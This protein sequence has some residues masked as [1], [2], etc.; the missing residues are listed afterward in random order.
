M[1]AKY[2]GL[3]L[4]G[5]NIKIAVIENVDGNWNIIHKDQVATEAISGPE[6]VTN[7][8]ANLAAKYRNEFQISGVGLAVPGIFDSKAGT[9]SL[10]PNLP[11]QWRGFQILK[12]ITEAAKVPVSL[13]NDARAFSLAESVLGAARGY[14]TVA[15]IVMGTGVGGGIVINGKVHL[16]ATDG[17]GEIAHQIVNPDGPICGCGSQGC[18][19]AMTSSHA[20]AT[21]AGVATP[22]EAFERA[23]AG[24]AQAIKAFEEAGKWIGIAMANV[25]AILSPDVYVLGGGVSQSGG[26]ITK[27]ALAEAH[28][29]S[30]LFDGE[31]FHVLPAQLD[32]FAGAIGAA[33]NGSAVVDNNPSRISTT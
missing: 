9:I 27:Y 10:F 28:R 11:G 31:V 2:L 5:T 17:A 1:N 14:Q 29:R 18:V 30:H 32:V 4:G 21:Y 22:E 15:C 12:P 3:D 19:E 16:G 23:I 24:D 13:I 7:R 20:I 25:M 33:L 26:L 6:H 8:L